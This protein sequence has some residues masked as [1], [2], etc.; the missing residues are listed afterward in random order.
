MKACMRSREA[1]RSGPTIS[2]ATS[3]SRTLSTSPFRS[4][5][6]GRLNTRFGSTSSAPSS[7]PHRLGEVRAQPR[8]AA[9][10]QRV[11]DLVQR[12]PAQQ[13]VGLGLEVDRGLRE[14]RR[15][16]QQPRRRLGLED[17]ELVLAQ[18]A[19]AEEARRWRRPRPRAARPP[20]APTTPESGP[21]AAAEAVRRP[22]RAPSCSESGCSRIQ[23][24]R[25]TG[26]GCG[27]VSARRPGVLGDEP[28]ALLGGPG[29][30]LELRGVRGGLEA[31]DPLRDG[32]G[33]LPVD[34]PAHGGRVT[35]SAS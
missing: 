1:R 35:L 17:R 18:H 26:S 8:H 28:R 29:D 15:D 25:S 20:A 34:H 4:L 11:R 19:L 12:D 6:S 30:V 22:G 13:L 10:L 24:G 23:S 16:E 32:G 14:V 33:E 7:S 5:R 9:E 27:S 3:P 31:G 2:V 21:D